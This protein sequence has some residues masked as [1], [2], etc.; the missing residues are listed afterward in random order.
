MAAGAKERAKWGPVPVPPGFAAARSEILTRSDGSHVSYNNI[1]R[2]CDLDVT[3]VCRIFTRK[4]RASVKTLAK[5]ASYLGVTM[6]RLN[7]VLTGSWEA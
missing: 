6:D 3:F 1:A 5:I 2:A 4:R 7:L